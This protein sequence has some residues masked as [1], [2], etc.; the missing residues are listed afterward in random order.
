MVQN[1]GTKTG[2]SAAGATLCL[3]PSETSTDGALSGT[4][5]DFFNVSFEPRS[6]D[7][8]FSVALDVNNHLVLILPDSQS[9]KLTGLRV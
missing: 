4:A 1:Y 5:W 9:V 3:I 7:R 2:P 6:R 8:V